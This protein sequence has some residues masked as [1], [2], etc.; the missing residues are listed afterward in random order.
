M[1]C[2][3]QRPFARTGCAHFSTL[4]RSPSA[5]AGVAF[6][7]ALTS[8]L[9]AFAALG[10]AAFSGEAFSDAAFA[11]GGFFGLFSAFFSAM[12][13]GENRRSPRRVKRPVRVLALQ[14]SPDEAPGNR[15]TIKIISL[16]TGN[17]SYRRAHP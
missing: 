5:A 17:L 8:P 4:Q 11:A 12:A 10:A 2:F 1:K 3:R 13:A 9:G 15:K 16:S 6:E 7:R 14:Q